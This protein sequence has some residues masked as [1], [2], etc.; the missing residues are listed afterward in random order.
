MKDTRTFLVIK[1]QLKKQL[2]KPK[3]SERDNIKMDLRETEDMRT[4]VV[5]MN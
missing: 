4:D 2:G 1:C 5:Q 3:S